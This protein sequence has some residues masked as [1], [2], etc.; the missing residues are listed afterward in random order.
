MAV[1]KDLNDRITD[2]RTAWNGKS[3]EQVEDF[4]SKNLV[5]GM[6]YDNST[7]TIMEM[8]LM[9]MVVEMYQPVHK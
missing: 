2:V 5:G 9:M 3:G 6:S 1:L 7:L 8:K 4:I